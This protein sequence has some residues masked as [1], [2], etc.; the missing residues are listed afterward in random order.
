MTVDELQN[1]YDEFV[2][3]LSTCDHSEIDDINEELDI[4]EAEIEFRRAQGEI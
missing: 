1:K 4:I 2:D 3:A